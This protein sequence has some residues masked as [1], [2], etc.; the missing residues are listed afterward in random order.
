[1]AVELPPEVADFLDCCGGRYPDIDEGDVRGLALRVRTFATNTRGPFA[2]GGDENSTAIAAC[3]RLVATWTGAS[4]DHQAELDHICAVIA[5]ALDAVAYVITVTKAVVLTELAAL[6]TTYVAMTATP[7]ARIAGPLVTA[8]A[9]R[10]CLQMERALIGYLVADVIAKAIEPLGRRSDHMLTGPIPDR[11]TPT[12]STADLQLCTVSNADDPQ[13][14]I[15][16]RAEDRQRSTVTSDD[17]QPP[18]VAGAEVAQWPALTGGE[19]ISAPTVTGA[20]NPLRST[21]T[22][23]DDLGAPTLA[24]NEAPQQRTVTRAGDPQWGIAA[25]AEDRQRSIATGDDAQS[26]TMTG[27]EEPEVPAVT[28]ARNPLRPTASGAED[29]GA[30]ILTGNEYP[31]RTVT[32]A[33]GPQARTTSGAEDRQRSTSTRGDEQS[34]TVTD[35]DGPQSLTSAGAEAALWSTATGDD[36]WRQSTGTGADDSVPIADDSRTVYRPGPDDQDV[37]RGH[38]PFGPSRSRGFVT[39]W[40]HAVRASAQRASFPKAVPPK[41]FQSMDRH[42]TTARKPRETPW[43]KLNKPEAE[44]GELTSIAT[45]PTVRR[46]RMRESGSD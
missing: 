36:D 7:A 21:M 28:S 46:G 4:G 20:R 5:K 23:A 34:S 12:A 1:M 22:G 19:D 32:R 29:A 39:P 24:G 26:P 17:A 43:S 8:A 14:R 45:V 30:P 3:E 2:S 9:R 40:A 33:E 37:P 42:A 16:A 38:Q 35:A 31:P 13:A 44:P 6:A 25:G 27:A 15:A 11:E 18:A 41:A 10:L